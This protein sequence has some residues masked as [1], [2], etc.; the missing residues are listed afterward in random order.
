MLVSSLK[1]SCCLRENE[2][3]RCNSSCLVFIRRTCGCINKSFSLLIGLPRNGAADAVGVSSIFLSLFLSHF[4][5]S[6]IFKRL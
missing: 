5:S 3:E 1:K 4:L 6:I 2:R